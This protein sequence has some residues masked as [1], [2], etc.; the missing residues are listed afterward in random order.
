MMSSII[1][2]GQKRCLH[3]SGTGPHVF[4]NPVPQEQF[5]S[6]HNNHL[7]TQIAL[8]DCIDIVIHYLLIRYFTACHP[9]TMPLTVTSSPILNALTVFMEL[10]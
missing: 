8:A 4:H 2:K 6:L 1:S 10:V 9:S 5:S 7:P 3:L